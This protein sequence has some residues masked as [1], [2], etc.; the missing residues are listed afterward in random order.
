MAKVSRLVTRR[1]RE[2]RVALSAAADALR[3]LSQHLGPRL[4]RSARTAISRAQDA[5]R[6]HARAD[7][8]IWP[9]GYNVISRVQAKHVYDQIRRL[10]PHKRP[11]QVRDAFALVLFCIDQDTAELPFTREELA[12][13]IGCL[14][15][16]VSSIMG[17]LEEL[18]VLKRERRP[19]NGFRGRGRVVY[20][21]NVFTA[22][23]GSLE[24]RKE[25]AATQVP[26][27]EK[28]SKLKLVPP[29]AP[30]K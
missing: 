8:G 20:V 18:G 29:A 11:V 3:D 28:R 27:T 5:L 19:E 1:E 12:T 15:S 23:N 17:T 16:H 10:P 13:E 7:E 30:A 21:V 14:P 24:F 6:R 4:P 26:P 22:W 2:D 9:G 25:I